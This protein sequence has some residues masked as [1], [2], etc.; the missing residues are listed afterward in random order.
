MKSKI[1]SIVVLVVA[2]FAGSCSKQ[3]A[4]EIESIQTRTRDEQQRLEACS[5]VNFNNGLLEYRNVKLLFQCTKWDKEFP[6][7]YQSIN[8]ITADSWNHIFI[9]L[10]DAFLE[11]QENRNRTFKNIRDL[12]AGEGLDDLSHVITALN[13]TN[14]FDSVKAMFKCIENPASEFCNG[15]KNIPDKQKLKQ[16]I[17]ILNINEDTI[18][19]LSELAKKLNIVLA[20]KQEVLRAEVNKFR[21]NKLYL[22]TRLRLVDAVLNKVKTGLTNE[23]RTF[24]KTILTI[25]DKAG[26]NSWIYS[27]LTSDKMNREKFRDLLE[28]PILINPNFIKDIKG[29]KSLYDETFKCSYKKD[30]TLNNVFEFDLKNGIGD[31][32]TVLKEKNYK[33]FYDFTSMHVTGIKLASE[34]CKELVDNKY[35]ASLLRAAIKVAEFFQD[36][37]NYDLI[38]FILLNST[39]KA[40]ADKTFAENIYFGDLLAS[41]I[42]SSAVS[43]GG[44]ISAETR[45]FFPVIYDILK[46][47]PPETVI[48]LAN[49]VEEISKVE[50]DP[51]FVGVAQFWSFFNDEEKNFVFNFL[52]RH[53][54][55]NINYPLLFDFYSKFLD[56][57]R[58]NLGIFKN[59]WI[60]DANLDEKNYLALEDLFYNFS[61]PE[62]LKDFK[63]FFSRDHIIRVLELLSNGNSLVNDAKYEIKYRD[64]TRYVTQAKTSKY[65]YQIKYNPAAD[66]DYDSKELVLC[67]QKFNELDKG[68]YELIRNLP[69]ACTAVT[70]QN[71]SLRMFGWLNSIEKEYAK[72]VKTNT[73]KDSLFNEEGI[74]GPH[75]LTTN[76]GLIKIA[77]GLIG[78][79]R[80]SLPANKGIN[81]LIESLDFYLNQKNGI[82]LMNSNLNWL[83]QF[84]NFN[85]QK[86]IG[87][88]NSLIKSYTKDSN[89]TYSRNV[90]SSISYLMDRFGTWISSGNYTKAA[91]RKLG[92][93]DPN[94]DCRKLINQKIN[95]YG[96]PSVPVIKQYGNELLS[97][98]QN[99]WEPEMGSTIRHLMNGA[100]MG[101]GLNIP[102]NSSRP[103]KYR[104]SLRE[105]AKYLYDTFDR[106]LRVNNQNMEYVNS[107][108]QKTIENVTTVERVET[109]IREV[110]FE[111]NYLGAIYLNHVVW[112]DDYNKD[113]AERKKLMST[114]LKIPGVRCGRKMSDS[115]LRMAKNALE[116]YDSLLDVNNG[117]GLEPRLQYGNFLKAFQQTLIASSSKAAQE[118]TFFPLPD[119]VLK[120]HNGKVLGHISMLSGFSNTAR[121]LR[122]RVGRTRA[123][124]E[125]FLNRD[126]VKRVDRT[127]MAGFDLNKAVPVA[128]RIVS[129]LRTIQGNDKQNLFE[130]TVD[131]LS[132]LSYEESL[133]VEDTIG[134]LMVV[135]SYLGTPD[136]VF[137]SN[138]NSNDFARY[139][140]NNLFQIFMAVD[141]LIDYWPTLKLL[142]PADTK[143]IDAVKP[144]N[145]FLYF[146]TEELNSNTDPYKNKAYIALNDVF[147]LFQ[148]VLFDDFTDARIIGNKA[149]SYKGLDFI[150]EGLKDK[151]FVEKT[152]SLIRSN[153]K[154][155]DNF[156]E[157]NGKFF[158][159]AAQNINRLVQS[160]QIDMQPIKDYLNFT[161]K[162]AV[163]TVGDSNC[164]ANYHYDEVANLIK[165]LNKKDQYGKTYLEIANKKL[166]LE[167]KNSIEE[168]I[169]DLLPAIKIKKINPPLRL[170]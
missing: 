140:N 58:D 164:V 156:F 23:D 90:F 63:K 28:Y 92:T 146:L 86:N 99:V 158:N 128:E 105:N 100:I 59:A 155:M 115:D 143:L 15:R 127:L 114:C 57:S 138:V 123:D 98:V 69:A 167:N 165:F 43:L 80:T 122:D 104:L 162:N 83:D 32:V 134:R 142:Y 1:F 150:I 161:S 47:L 108:N 149:E 33:A 163:C 21:D 141:R 117:R 107:A 168:M 64:S 46:N 136:I 82:M 119:D 26:N 9:P 130:N 39:T 103:T 60:G 4:P 147:V 77:D 112:G 10:N 11:G 42:F 126:D 137:N 129:K 34:S 24:L 120:K 75:M 106:G 96:C 67:L 40:D 159:T 18:S 16:I 22:L 125:K 55:E 54:D 78:P 5:V 148:S 160:V 116:A 170:N 41:D 153:Y 17:H 118:V 38:K 25:G 48:H 97:M 37:N 7:L 35:D 101:G 19:D 31:Y 85:L 81:Y 2:F 76:I 66:N 157:D 91:N 121:F 20:P 139:R 70:E 84:L 14:F 88:R 95:P 102:F 73:A 29:V 79:Y 110:R 166:L 135:G 89:F 27:W 68:L 133:L 65:E 56:H 124:F 45:E 94:N 62:T 111:N 169:N 144:L 132:T 36:K 51:K 93:Y 12:D 52:D 109:V 151:S 8:S 30:S 71:I 87:F 145:N 3:S 74:L 50:N 154:F 131:W 113:V 44:S 13:E 152:Y 6:S 72:T 53:F 61:G 49:L